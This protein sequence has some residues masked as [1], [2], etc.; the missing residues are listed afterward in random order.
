M[1]FCT[2]SYGKVHS[3]LCTFKGATGKDAFIYIYIISETR[4]SSGDTLAGVWLAGEKGGLCFFC[5]LW[6]RIKAESINSSISPSASAPPCHPS[7]FHSVHLLKPQPTKGKTQIVA[8]YYSRSW[9]RGWLEVIKADTIFF[10]LSTASVTPRK[11]RK[12]GT[13][14]SGLDWSFQWGKRVKN[15]E[16]GERMWAV[17]TGM[18]GD[19]QAATLTHPEMWM[20]LLEKYQAHKG[21][22]RHHFCE[23]LWAMKAGTGQSEW[24]SWG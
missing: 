7:P 6:P 12:K 3:V 16:K 17:C 20:T 1:L 23:S 9:T 21:T 13:S 19:S 5:S 10:F 2:G 15:A 14:L 24:A 8:R 22:V 18:C 4:T 11:S